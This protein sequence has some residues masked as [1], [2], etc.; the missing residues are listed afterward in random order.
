MSDSVD[1]VFSHALNTVNKIRTGSQK[2][3]SATRLRLYGLYKQAMEGDVDGIMERPSGSSEQDVRAREKWDA[4]KQQNGL[5]RTEAKRRYITTLI[6]TMH[7]F[8]SPSPDSR[9]LVAEL[10]FVWDQVKSNVP[11]SSSSSP[12]QTL[13]QMGMHMPP[14]HSY[15]GESRR[16]HR[17]PQEEDEDGPLQIKSPMSQSEEELEEEEAEID[18]EEFVDAPDSQYNPN[19]DAEVE[20]DVGVQTDPKLTQLNPM[21]IDTPTPAARMRSILPQSIPM[22]NFTSTPAPAKP[23]PLPESAADKKW[24]ARVEL[25]LQKMTAEVA[26]LREQLEA[27]R[28][29]SH[30]PHYRLIRGIWRWVWAAL[31]H[32]AV[33]VF[34]LGIVLL[35]MRRKK[36]TRLEG[37]IRVLL[38]D[39]V[40][41]VQKVGGRQLGKVKLPGLGKKAGT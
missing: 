4:W 27:R 32:V 13:S 28:L 16:D 37:A 34:I 39:A 38:G 17:R 25:A 30:S 19:D 24:R 35:Y 5:S 6:D 3:P 11:S 23:G 41:Q 21:P 36:D 12:M 33:D 22:P 26:A 40:A 10:E 8:A 15:M 9:E 7:K 2:P 14:S 20:V 31:K 1:R 18:G 29:F